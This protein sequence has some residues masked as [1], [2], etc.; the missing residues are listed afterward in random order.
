MLSNRLIGPQN[1]ERLS[2]DQ[3]IG[4]MKAIVK[5]AEEDPVDAQV[6]ARALAN[7]IIPSADDTLDT[8][9]RELLMIETARWEMVA[10]LRTYCQNTVRLL[11]LD[12]A[13][14]D[15]VVQKPGKN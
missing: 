10:Q 13:Y 7:D 4:L 3:T 6:A 5:D 8:L 9:R 11:A 15:K 12:N 2:E 1:N 14:S